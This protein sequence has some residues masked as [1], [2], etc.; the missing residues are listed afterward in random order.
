MDHTQQMLYQERRKMHAPERHSDESQEQYRERR[1]QSQ[2]HVAAVAQG[3]DMGI[4]PRRTR[5]RAGKAMTKA[6]KRARIIEKL[7]VQKIA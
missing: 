4:P 1:G 7:A 2:K 5:P 6:M 3:W